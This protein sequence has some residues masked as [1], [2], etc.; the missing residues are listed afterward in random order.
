MTIRLALRFLGIRHVTV[1]SFEKEGCMCGDGSFQVCLLCLI[2]VYA[3][4]CFL[5]WCSTYLATTIPT[6]LT[7]FTRTQ[8]RRCSSFDGQFYL[9][10]RH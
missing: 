4:L 10:E 9:E 6:L 7:S 8:P 2:A 5:S 3:V 1:L